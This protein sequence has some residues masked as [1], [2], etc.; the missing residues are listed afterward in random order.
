MQH[1]DKS[2]ILFVINP[3]SGRKNINFIL[4]SIRK[5]DSEIKYIITDSLGQLQEVMDNEFCNYKVFVAVG[6]DGTVNSLINYLINHNDKSLA[7]IP[8][9]SGNGFA[10]ELGFKFDVDNLIK[11]IS[12][13]E[14]IDIDVLRI[15]KHCF[16]NLAGIGLDAE[17]AHNFQKSGERGFIS[18]IFCTIRSYFS[19]KP[20]K[21]NITGNGIDING[22][23]Q[24]ISIANT[25][26]F[27]NN[28]LISPT[29]KP[30]DRQFEIVMLKTIPIYLIPQFVYRLFKGNLKNSEYINY[31]SSKDPVSIKTNSNR[32]HIDGD[33]FVSDGNYEISVIEKCL[34]IIKMDS[35]N[36]SHF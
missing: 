6:G 12:T 14:T 20:I 28:A 29:S 36:I 9:G 16:I 22:T 21:A 11:Q 34:R 8:I 2:E 19:F 10:N 4:K 31:L 3:N 30:Y 32:F 5:I 7:I 13:G 25:R 35:I 26:Q 23:Y 27:G 33:P 17:I 15:N 1:I 18:Y 24:M